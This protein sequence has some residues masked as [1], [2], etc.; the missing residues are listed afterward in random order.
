MFRKFEKIIRWI[1][2]FPQPTPGLSE[3]I[4]F[5]SF[6]KSLKTD[7]EEKLTPLHNAGVDDD[8][9]AIVHIHYEVFFIYFIYCN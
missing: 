5:Y 9:H 2:L 6:M 3:I 8:A 1:T 7:L 4:L